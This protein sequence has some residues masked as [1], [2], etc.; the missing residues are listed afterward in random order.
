MNLKQTRDID[1]EIAYNV[2]HLGGFVAASGGV[3]SDRFIRSGGLGRLTPAGV[4]ALRDRGVT[5]VIDLRSP[6]E[7]ET[8]A[9]PDLNAAGIRVIS[10]PV[11]QDD[12]TPAR[13]EGEW[14][15]TTVAYQQL[16]AAGTNAF[17]TLCETIAEGDRAVLFHCTAGKDRTGVA[18]ALLLDFAGVDRAQIAADHARSAELLESEFARFAVD[19]KERGFEPYQID[20]MLSSKAEDMAATLQYITERWGSAEG[21]LAECGVS[22]TARSAVRM[23]MLA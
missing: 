12:L 13:Y 2:R 10:A 5:T 17:R 4:G 15:P 22:A 6:K 20:Q 1:V 9:T 21:Y 23:R 3:T 18:A 7:Q 16:L 14:V 19:M 8:E 11:F